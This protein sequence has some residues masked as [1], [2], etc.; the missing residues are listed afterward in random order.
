MAPRKKQPQKAEADKVTAPK[1]AVIPE[2][3]PIIP[4]RPKG[5]SYV[6]VHRIL[7][8]P[9]VKI[10]I[11]TGHPGVQLEKVDSWLQSQIDAGLVKEL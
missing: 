5:K 2:E 10:H 11:P 4:P 3:K 1:T 9:F 6:A 7:Y 8:H